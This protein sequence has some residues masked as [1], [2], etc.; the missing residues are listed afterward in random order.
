MSAVTRRGIRGSAAAVLG[1]LTLLSAC[2]PAPQGRQAES[3]GTGQ[4]QASARAPKVLTIVGQEGNVGDFPGV[5]GGSTASGWG[6]IHNYLVQRNDQDE[7]IAELAAEQISVDNGTWRINADGTM[8]TI[9][10][11]RPNVK[12]HDGAPFTSDDL[13]FSLNVFK[14]PDLPSRYGEAL[15]RIESATAPDPL[16]LVV[17]WSGPYAK[18]N[19][20]PALNPMA[21]HLLEATYRDD[22]ANFGNSPWFS[23][24][25]VG[26]GPYRMVKWEPGSHL[27]LERFDDY[28][29][30]RPPLDRVI[31]RFIKDPNTTVANIMSGAVDIAWGDRLTLESAVEVGQRW[32]GTGNQAKFA[33]LADLMQAEIQHRPEY[34]RPVNGLTNRQVRQAFYHA[35]D[36]KELVDAVMHGLAPVADSWLGPNHVIRR[37]VEGSIPQFPYDP[38]RAQQLLTEAGW[39]RGGDGVLV[40][41]QS[42]QPFEIQLAVM[43]AKDDRQL[44]IVADNWR[45]IGARVS[46]FTMPRPRDREL[47]ALQPGAVLA[48]PKAY[49]YAFDSRIYGGNISTAA[50][51]WTGRNRSGYSNQAVDSLLERL[52][53]TID[54]RESLEWH[55]QL[56]QAA[57]SDVSFMPLYFDVN[58][59]LMQKGVKGPIGGTSLEWNFFQWD[60]E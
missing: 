60:K 20:A 27:E 38:A 15:R 31:V 6:F 18:A 30:G 21:R 28:F 26:L 57:L 33:P 14:D 16:T 24:A 58:P 46:Q 32:Q 36:R 7:F 47:E 50:N 49:E 12:W 2:A 5:S 13:L 19:E 25:F 44:N 51:R 42:G 35:I 22:K 54:P 10:K 41:R 11:L 43:E 52:A 9:W 17:R 3:A 45:S 37:Q 29:L 8:D 48:S 1:L 4:S 23:S 53:V 56:L 39:V 59:I 40:D 34:A 55:R